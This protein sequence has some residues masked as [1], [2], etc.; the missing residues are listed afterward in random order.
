MIFYN[1]FSD[2][3]KMTKYKY[4]I[5]DKVVNRGKVY[6]ISAMRLTGRD[7]CNRCANDEPAYA[8][9]GFE[10]IAG[11]RTYTGWIP[12]HELSRVE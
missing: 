12:E 11:S 4:Q 10:H 8:L 3:W 7:Y 6:S 2:R 1:I 9:F 5:G